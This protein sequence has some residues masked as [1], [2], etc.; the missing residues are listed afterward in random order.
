MSRQSALLACVML[1]AAVAWGGERREQEVRLLFTGDILL[2]RQVQVEMEHR[3]LSP[4]SDLA[5][6]FGRADLVGGNFEGALGGAADCLPRANPCF[7]TPTSVVRQLQQAGF[8]TLTVENNHAGDLGADGR[9]RT[10]AALRE[11]GILALDFDSSPQF[12]RF[13]KFTLAIVAVNTVAAADGGV[14]RIPSPAIAQKLRLAQQLANLVV[15]SIHWGSEL[16]DWPNATQREQA[17]WLVAHGADL[18]VGHHPHVVQGPE[19]VG[20]KPVFFSLGNHVFDQKYPLTKEGLIA[21]CRITGERLNCA[22]LRTHT[23]SGSSIPAIAAEQP[24]IPA[25]ESCGA[26]L[27]PDL[28]IGATTIK[29]E[30]WSRGRPTKGLMLEGWRRGKVEWRSRRQEIVSLQVATFAGSQENPLLF[31]LERHASPIDH[32]VGIRPYVYAV[33]ERG[34]NARWR[35]SALAWPLLDAVVDD[36]GSLCALHRGDSFIALDPSSSSTRLARY[37]WNGFGFAAED[38]APTE[39]CARRWQ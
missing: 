2:T 31:T 15:V 37:R 39:S 4:W 5:G 33:G 11:A 8:K 3:K 7:A 26:T 28:R 23:R 13:G 1:L 6:E 24:P 36:D 32:E 25:L 17:E 29:P 35:G 30:A 38:A 16:V 14:Q 27:R 22:G 21:D 20:G 34:L 10:A 18:I 9:Q 12:L 19:C